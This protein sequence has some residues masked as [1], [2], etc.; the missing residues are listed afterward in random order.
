MR[1]LIGVTALL[2]ASGASY[3]A[4]LP[5]RPAQPRVAAPAVVQEK[6][7][8]GFYVGFNGGMNLGKFNPVFGTEDGAREVDLKDNSWLVGGHMGY[9]AQVGS[10][11]VGP[12]IGIQY[13]GLK[14]E[15]P[16]P[17]STVLLQQRIDWAAYAGARV[18]L[19][20]NEYFMPYVGGGVT[21]G[22]IKG[23]MVDVPASLVSGGATGWYV[24]G[25]AELRLA[26]DTTLGFEY[27]HMDFGDHAPALLLPADR[28]TIDQIV[29]RLSFRLN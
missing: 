17:D 24:A 3:A 8:Q 12:E 22:H 6:A 14:S 18:G 5:A 28:L 11:V 2:F 9:M 16:I 10:L 26:K 25:G 23:Q 15:A 7:W 29:G 13:W 1:M 27:R 19:A 20:L 21:W 4:D